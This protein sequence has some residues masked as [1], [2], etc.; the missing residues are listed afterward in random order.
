MYHCTA[1]LILIL[2]YVLVDIIARCCVV[3]LRNIVR[4]RNKCSSSSYS[5]WALPL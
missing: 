4:Q 2:Q 1:W 3:W 5:R